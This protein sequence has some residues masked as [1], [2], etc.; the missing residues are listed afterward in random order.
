MMR[1]NFM[2]RHGSLLKLSEADTTPEDAWDNLI[3]AVANCRN[4]LDSLVYRLRL[5][6]L[7]I[8][9]KIE[10]ADDRRAKYLNDRKIL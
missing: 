5:E 2:L 4:A 6:K 3:Q 1:L 8:Q 10:E 9:Q 7:A